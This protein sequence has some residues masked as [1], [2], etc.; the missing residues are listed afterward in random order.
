MTFQKSGVV[1][2]EVTL[3]GVG[4]ALYSL[5]DNSYCDDVQLGAYPSGLTKLN[6]SIEMG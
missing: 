2:S 5:W 4:G 3:W 6:Y 1:H